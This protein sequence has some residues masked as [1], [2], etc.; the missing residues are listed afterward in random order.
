[1][2]CFAG[3]NK[4]FVLK[5]IKNRNKWNLGEYLTVSESF[6]VNQSEMQHTFHRKWLHTALRTYGEK[7][8]FQ[9]MKISRIQGSISHGI[10]PYFVSWIYY[11]CYLFPAFSHDS[12]Q[13]F[14]S[15]P[16]FQK[17]PNADAAFSRCWCFYCVFSTN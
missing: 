1:M 11:L 14:I 9:R 12:S 2:Y 15:Y 13:E 3:V 10:Y 6:K 8:Y 17:S 7:M 16:V 4:N 5:V